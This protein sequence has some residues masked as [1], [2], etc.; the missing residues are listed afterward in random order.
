MILL[1]EQFETEQKE[2]K[3]L[4]TYEMM[5]QVTTPTTKHEKNE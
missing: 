2:L 5:M 4:E 3:I 1:I